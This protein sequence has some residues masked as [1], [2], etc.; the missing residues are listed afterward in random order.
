[1]GDVIGGI[2]DMLGGGKYDQPN[3]SGMNY[4]SS[5]MMQAYQQQMAQ[6]TALQQQALNSW[7]EQ[8]Q[9]QRGIQDELM[10]SWRAKNEFLQ[11]IQEG[12]ATEY[13]NI[14]DNGFDPSQSSLY[15]QQRSNIAQNYDLAGEQIMG[16]L[17]SGGLLQKALAENE[18]SRAKTLGQAQSDVEQFELNRLYSTASGGT[19]ALQYTGAGSSFPYLGQ[20]NTSG[21]SGAMQAQ[22]YSMQAQQQNQAAQL[23]KKGDLGYG[24]GSMLMFA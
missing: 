13:Q 15:R 12:A 19:P 9:Y 24:L 8:N 21:L 23:G 17:P 1:M 6:Q 18:S 22:A 4:L 11:P 20:A 14:M 16:Q 5:Q 2:G 10:G 7:E 3:T